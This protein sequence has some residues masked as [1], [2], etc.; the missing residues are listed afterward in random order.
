MRSREVPFEFRR[1]F[2]NDFGLD[3]ADVKVMFK[4][5]WSLEMFK[6]IV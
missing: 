3:V 5:P 2:S 4:N 6:K 1:R